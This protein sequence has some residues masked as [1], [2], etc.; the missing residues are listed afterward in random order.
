ML[1]IFFF[2]FKNWIYDISVFFCMIIFL[3]IYYICVWKWRDWIYVIKSDV[4]NFVI[5]YV[6]LF[7]ILLV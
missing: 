7:V 1:E 5:G 3:K 6:G 4:L 2:N